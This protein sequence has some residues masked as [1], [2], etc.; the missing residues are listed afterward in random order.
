MFHFAIS[1]LVQRLLPTKRNL[2]L[3][4]NDKARFR[5]LVEPL[6]DRRLLTTITDLGT[7]GGFF[8]GALSISSSGMLTGWAYDTGNAHFH[9]FI[10]DGTSM[11][12][13]G[14]FPGGNYSI[15]MAVNASG[16]VAGDGYLHN[17]AYHGFL[18]H[19]GQITD[20]G[21]FGGT[22]SEAL[23]INN[24]G[25]VVGY[26]DI[27]GSFSLAHAF[28]YFNGSMTQLGTLGGAQ[29]V[30]YGINQAGLVVGWATVPDETH[31]AYVYDGQIMTDLGTLGGSNSQALAIN[32]SG[33]IVGS[34]QPNGMTVDHAIL[35]ANGLMTDLGTLSGYDNSMAKSINNAGQIV[36]DVYTSDRPDWTYPFLYQNGVMADLNSF[37]PA[38][39]GWTL[40]DAASINDSGQIAAIGV[41]NGLVHA[42]LVTL[43]GLSTAENTPN[44]VLGTALNSGSEAAGTLGIPMAGVANCLA[45]PINPP[46]VEIQGLPTLAQPP[47]QTSANDSWSQQDSAMQAA[48]LAVTSDLYF[49]SGLPDGDLMV[50]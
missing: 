27:A 43:G 36:G 33:Q 21:T 24:T 37:L 41:H 29:S 16:D 18:Y 38:D 47:S 44:P 45:T 19:N 40:I 26:A 23:G 9:A 8:S 48:T 20:L 39:S 13:L 50:Q 22:F 30:A 46:T 32:D 10:S 35:Y 15:G 4:S 28:V 31:H 6:E 3:R 1:R 25:Q 17:L 12:D 14:V 49:A 11:K 2:R 7:L 42:C 34:S 5:P